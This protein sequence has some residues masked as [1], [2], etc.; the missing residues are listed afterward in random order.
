[1]IY[2]RLER[3]NTYSGCHRLFDSAIEFLRRSDL[4][5]ME[6]GRYELADGAYASIQ[7]YTT[8]PRSRCDYESHRK[9]VDVQFLLLGKEWIYVSSPDLLEVTHPY[10]TNEDCARYEGEAA[11]R[12]LARPGSFVVLFPHDAHMPTVAVDSPRRVKKVVVKLPV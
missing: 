3:A 9:Y 10:V 2:D 12:V 6:E 4:S 11:S 8:N 1:M 5:S 7:V